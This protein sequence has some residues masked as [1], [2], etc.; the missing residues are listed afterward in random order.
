[1]TATGVTNRYRIGDDLMEY[2]DAYLREYLPRENPPLEQ[3]SR[4]VLDEIERGGDLLGKDRELVSRAIRWTYAIFSELGLGRYRSD[5]FFRGIPWWPPAGAGLVSQVSVGLFDQESEEPGLGLIINVP[6]WDGPTFEVVDEI[7]FPRLNK[8]GFK[9]AI[10]QAE[11]DLHLGHPKG[12]TSACWAQCK[13]TSQWGV[14]T[15]GHA[16]GGNQPGRAVPMALGNVASLG[17]CYFQPVDAAFVLTLAPTHKPAP[18]PVLRFAAMGM[19][20]KIDCQS[21]Q[22]SRTVVEVQS[23]CGVLNTRQVGVSLYLDQPASPGDSGA[24]IRGANGDAVGLY[25]GAMNVPSA[26]TGTRG[27]AQ[28]FEQ[29]ILALDILPYL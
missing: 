14:L 6:Q 21:G 15:A 19:P 8:A 7:T 24:L 18:L 26:T 28:N 23:N 2:S 4:D 11:V 20:V 1:M 17:R 12:A 27:L 9:L 29:A 22:L 5:G 3:V 16:I 25:R 10:R 13:T